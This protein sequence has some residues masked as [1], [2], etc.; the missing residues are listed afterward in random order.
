MLAVSRPT[1]RAIRSAKATQLRRIAPVPRLT[2]SYEYDFGDSWQHRI[3]VEKV[4]PPEPGVRYPRCLAG[5]R[6]RPPEDVGAIFARVSD[7]VPPLVRLAGI[8]RR[9]S[10]LFAGS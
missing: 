4:L 1:V 3:E 8:A 2:F 10:A 6:A 9:P 7:M 5:K